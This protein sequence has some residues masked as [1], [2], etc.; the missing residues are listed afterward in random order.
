MGKLDWVRTFLAIGPRPNAGSDWEA[1][2][3]GE[4]SL[5]IDLNDSSSERLRA[6]ELG[7]QYLGLKIDDPP[8][9]PESLTH[10]FR[11]I[12]ASIDEERRSGGKV[13]LHCT[14]GQQRSPTCAMAY[15]MS[16]GETRQNAKRLVQ[17]ARLGVWAGPVST[18]TW[19]RALELWEQELSKAKR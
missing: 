9:N 11:R 8:T 2:E 16:N 18:A 4:I 6:K 19:E 3:E 14:A 5:I 1:F 7:I 15:L 13:Y 17:A 12:C 10:F